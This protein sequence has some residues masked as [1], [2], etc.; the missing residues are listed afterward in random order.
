MNIAA[1]F[2]S[3]RRSH[4][5]TVLYTESQLTITRGRFSIIRFVKGGVLSPFV[6]GRN[7]G[8]DSCAAF[9]SSDALQVPIGTTECYL[10]MLWLCKPNDSR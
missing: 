10:L 1:E 6:V 7:E 8:K 4:N 2:M 9:A 5:A 3:Y